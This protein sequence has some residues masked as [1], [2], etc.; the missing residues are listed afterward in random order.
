MAEWICKACNASNEGE[1]DICWQCGTG[2]DGTPPDPAFDRSQE[3]QHESLRVLQCLRCQSPMRLV[4][5]RRFREGYPLAPFLIA[6][7]G[8]LLSN[9]ESFDL[10][11]CTQCGKV[12]FFLS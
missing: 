12:E 7:L 5:T 10:Y 2:Y 4:G 3:T 6:E 1:F 8:D 11:A 9:R